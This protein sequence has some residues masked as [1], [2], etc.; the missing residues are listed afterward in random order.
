MFVDSE[1]VPPAI[2][3]PS[4]AIGQHNNSSSG[5][6]INDRIEGDDLVYTATAKN[7]T[8]VRKDSSN[9]EF[10]RENSKQ[11]E[12]DFALTNTKKTQKSVQFHEKKTSKD[13]PSIKQLKEL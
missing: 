3:P 13:E 5:V 8:K 6:S 11:E 9:T 7:L 4:N 12:I 1:P 2:L 10:E